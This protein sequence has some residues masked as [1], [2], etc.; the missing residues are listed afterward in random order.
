MSHYT[1]ADLGRPCAHCGAR[2]VLAVGFH[3][4]CGPVALAALALDRRRRP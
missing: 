2:V 1:P 3:P 4:V